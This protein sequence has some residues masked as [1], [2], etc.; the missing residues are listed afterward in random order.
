MTADIKVAIHASRKYLYML[1]RNASQNNLHCKV[2]A[3]E[4]LIIKLY[5]KFRL[6]SAPTRPTVTQNYSIFGA[7]ICFTQEND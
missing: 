3:R 2:G 7:N 6:N 5:Q 1:Y 4:I